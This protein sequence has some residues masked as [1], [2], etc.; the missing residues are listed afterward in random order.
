VELAAGSRIEG[1]FAQFISRCPELPLR[2]SLVASGTRKFAAWNTPID[3]GDE[4]A[5]SSASKRRL[6][7]NHG[8]SSTSDERICRP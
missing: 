1:S 4:I 8:D 3:S 6:E 2:G 7:A 5:L